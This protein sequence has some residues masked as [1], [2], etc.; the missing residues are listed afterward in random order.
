[1]SENPR[2]ASTVSSWPSADDYRRAIAELQA[3]HERSEQFSIAGSK[4]ARFMVL[5][6]LIEHTLT[7]TSSAMFLLDNA[8]QPAAMPLI[9][10]AF[11]H[12]I[13]AQWAHLHP[14]GIEGFIAEANRNQ[15]NFVAAASRT[16]RAPE[17]VHEILETFSDA[18]QPPAAARRF[19]EMCKQFDPTGELYLVY[20]YLSGWVHP[21]AA[22]IHNYSKYDTESLTFTAPLRRPHEFDVYMALYPA[23]FAVILASGVYEDLR[24]GKPNK[25]TVERVASSVGLPRLLKPEDASPQSQRD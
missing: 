11:E 24:R 3:L 15:R 10:A 23:A 4:A 6:G 16:P 13:T 12:A 14:A 22:T 2:I 19:E 5:N 25:S 18:T 8:M 1:M 21:G 9:R 7:L 17:E 20:R